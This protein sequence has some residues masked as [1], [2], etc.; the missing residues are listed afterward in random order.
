MSTLTIFKPLNVVKDI[1]SRFRSSQ[2]VPP[3]GA[4]PFLKPEEALRDRIIITITPATHTTHNAMP[5]KEQLKLMCRIL[6][7]SIGVQNHGF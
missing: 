7:S 1:C 6:C 3:M 2:I 5:F 4:F